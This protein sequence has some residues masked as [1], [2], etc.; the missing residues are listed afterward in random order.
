MF[1][2]RYSYLCNKVGMSPNKV[3]ADANLFST[4][5]ITKYKNGASPSGDIL[6]KVAD[7]FNVSVDYLLGRD[8]PKIESESEDKIRIILSQLSDESRTLYEDY[9]DFLIWRQG[10]ESSSCE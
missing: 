8:I 7:Y 9:L 6:M 4:G 1:W 3:A 2:E 10:R 5:M